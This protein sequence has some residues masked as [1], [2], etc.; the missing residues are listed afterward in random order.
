MTREDLK[1][2]VNQQ[3]E[4]EGLWFVAQYASEAYLQAALRKLHAYVEDFIDPCT[5]KWIGKQLG[6]HP[7]DAESAEWICYCDVCGIEKTDE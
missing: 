7:A 1:N 4:D 3:A 2:L 6:G 5:H